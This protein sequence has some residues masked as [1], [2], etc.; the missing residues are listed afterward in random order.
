MTTYHQGREYGSAQ[1]FWFGFSMGT[2]FG[3]GATIA[4]LFWWLM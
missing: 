4:A 3:I 1:Q 2:V